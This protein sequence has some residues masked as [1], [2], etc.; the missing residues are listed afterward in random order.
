[1]A[2]RPFPVDPTL[3]AISIGYRNPA[4]TLIG[5][6]ALPP[7]QVLAE[8]FKWQK[9]SLNEGFDVP[10]AKVGRLGQVNQVTFSG[11]EEDSSVEDY[12]L[13]SPVPH[14]D[15][16]A[17]A[18]A[19]AEKRS[20]FD[21]EQRAVE[22]L[23][24]YIE[25]NREKRAA[26]VVQNSANF[27][28]AR[29]TA[30]AGTAQFSDYANSDPFGVISTG[31]E[32]TLV[33]RPNTISMGQVV[34]SVLRRHPKLLKAVKGGLTDEGGITRQQ[35]A[36]LF[37]ISPDRLLIGEAW[38]N[39]AKPG[40]AV[41]LARIWGNSIQLTYLDESKG[42][43]KDGQLTWG[44]TAEYGNRVSGAIDDPDIGLEGGRRVRV[45]ERV[46]ELVCALD[47]GYQIAD[48]VGD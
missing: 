47:V 11:G 32:K 25:I 42:D 41:N 37:E 5:R 38:L 35:F 8:S 26:A 6:R 36:E 44:F 40:Q 19:R 29:K 3:T 12:G 9:F 22:G 33:Y 13:D 15:V 46:R 39:V 14:S 4:H 2:K 16:K 17:A 10:D 48:P 23:T 45:G 20:T 7:L 31:F 21:P 1:M 27:A 34:W 18:Q 30:L 43:S 24:N 28:A